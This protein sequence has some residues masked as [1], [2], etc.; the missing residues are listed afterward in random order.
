MITL[1][2]LT[3]ISLDVQKARVLSESMRT[4]KVKKVELQ[5][6]KK[7]RQILLKDKS[8]VKKR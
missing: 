6:I 8:L 4:K 1:I 7:A 5:E 3:Q 2:L